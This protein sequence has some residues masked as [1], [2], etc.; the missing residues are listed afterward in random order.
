MFFIFG[1]GD[2]KTKLLGQ[3][4]L[5]DCPRCSNTTEWTIHRQKTYFSLFFI[6]L[7]P[8]RTEFILSCPVCREA[9]E[10][11]ES[12]KDELLSYG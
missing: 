3:T 2:K 7:I 6:P 10:I 12:E 5:M 4:P 11:D 9:R 1:I 8:Y